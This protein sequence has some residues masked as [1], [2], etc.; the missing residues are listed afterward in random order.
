LKIFGLI[1]FSNTGQRVPLLA[2]LMKQNKL[3]QQTRSKLLASKFN[4]FH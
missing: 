2:K 3:K 4:S 1:S